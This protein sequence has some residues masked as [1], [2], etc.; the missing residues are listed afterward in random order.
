MATIKDLLSTMIGK[1]NEN[2]EAIASGGGG[3]G[4]TSWNDLED[5]PFGATSVFENIIIDT[6]NL[7][8]TEQIVD[9]YGIVVSRL[10]IDVS[11]LKATDFINSRFVAIENYVEGDDTQMHGELILEDRLSEDGRSLAYIVTPNDLE[12]KEKNSHR[13]IFVEEGATFTDG[14]TTYTAGFWVRNRQTQPIVVF[15]FPQKVTKIEEKFLPNFAKCCTIIFGDDFAEATATFEEILENIGMVFK[16][17]SDNTFTSTTLV[18]T[19]ISE[20]EDGMAVNIRAYGITASGESADI[21]SSVDF[22]CTMDG[23]QV[24]ATPN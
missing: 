18:K 15:I 7:N 12:F 8:Y 1:I 23:I 13:Y 14:N 4:V 19:E 6:N 17:V 20:T 24:F 2:S 9:D 22:I 5:K 10:N 21:T 16:V 3:G 11:N